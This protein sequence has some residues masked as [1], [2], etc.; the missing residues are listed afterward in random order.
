METWSV[1]VHLLLA[2][3]PGRKTV[4]FDRK[5]D[6]LLANKRQ[7]SREIRHPAAGSDG[8]HDRLY[9]GVFN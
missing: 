6:E 1:A 9:D 5:L 2:L 8:D 4:S 7:L 3:L